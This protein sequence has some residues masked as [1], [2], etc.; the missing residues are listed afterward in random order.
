MISRTKIRSHLINLKDYKVIKEISRGGFGIVYLVENK[1]SHQRF[2]A[3]VNFQQPTSMDEGDK[4]ISREIGILVRVQAPTI[5][6]FSGFSLKDFHGGDNVTILMEY[7][8]KGSLK[9]LIDL[10][11]RI[12]APPEYDNTVKQIILCGVAHGMM[13][14]HSRRVIHRDLKPDNVLLDSNYHPCITDFGLSKFLD[15]D[16]SKSQ[17]M[18]G[19]GTTAYMAPEVLDGNHYGP[20]SDVYSYGIL[21]YEV[22]TGQR[23]Y[24][25]ELKKKHFNFFSFGAKIIHENK[26]PQFTSPI[27]PGIQQLIERCWSGNPR[28]RPSFRELFNKLS[29]SLEDDDETIESKLKDIIS[30]NLKVKE[31]KNEDED[32]NEE[33]TFEYSQYC[34]DN[35]DFDQLIDYVEEITA[36]QTTTNNSKQATAKLQQIIEEQAKHID[37]LGQRNQREI[38]ELK[39]QNQLTIQTIEEQSKRLTDLDQQHKQEV[40]ELKKHNQ[41]QQEQIDQLTKR[42]QSQQKELDFLKSRVSGIGSDFDKEKQLK[43]PELAPALNFQPEQ[44]DLF[45]P[46]NG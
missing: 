23:A 43:T 39:K 37:E 31:D 44:P 45:N 40:T 14:L 35:V 20:K 30:G 11:E 1:K 8:E 38:T 12:Q 29:L 4:F 26:R 36:T 18:S 27:K 3:K 32:E 46:L 13:I 15:P 33:E 42:N 17:S 22:V 5:I 25:D 28:E 21:M 6:R 41:F 9:Q 19:C 16:H 24:S 34:L 10:E 2:A 7:K